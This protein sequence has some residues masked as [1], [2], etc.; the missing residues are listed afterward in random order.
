MCDAVVLYPEG[1]ANIHRIASITVCFIRNFCRFLSLVTF[2]SKEQNI[3]TKWTQSLPVSICSAVSS[4][5]VSVSAVIHSL[6]KWLKQSWPKCLEASTST[7]K[8][9][10]TYVR[11]HWDS[12][13]TKR[14]RR[15]KHSEK[16]SGALWPEFVTA[17]HFK[18]TFKTLEVGTWADASPPILTRQ[19]CNNSREHICKQWLQV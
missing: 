18:L 1:M 8:Y 3:W 9:R 13:T 15:L 16:L 11:R 17:Q 14:G 4:V 19:Y 10:S 7:K 6:S 2:C 12:S 5:Q